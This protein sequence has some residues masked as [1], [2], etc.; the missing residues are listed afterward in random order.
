MMIFTVMAKTRIISPIL[1]IAALAAF[2]LPGAAH[3]QTAQTASAPASAPAPLPGRPL[4]EVIAVAND[5]PILASALNQRIAEVTQALRARGTA[6]PTEEVLRRQVLERL[7]THKLQL[8]AADRQGIRISADQINEALSSIAARNGLTLAELPKALE[9]QGR[10]YLAFRQEIKEQLII[11]QLVRQTVAS[12]IQVTPTE[13]DHY[14]Q[15]QDNASGG[16]VEYRLAQ[17]LVTF[18]A[19]ATPDQ[20][21]KAREKAQALVAQIKAGADFA[22]TAV[23]NSGG[24]HA[25]EGG[26]IG[27]IKA[28]SLPT[29]FAGVVPTLKPGEI[30]APIVGVGG[31]HIVKLVDKRSGLPANTATEYHIR[32]ILLKPNPIRDLEQSKVLAETL[33]KQVLSGEISFAEAAKQYSNDPNSAGIGGD[34]EW[35]TLQRLPPAFEPV[36]KNLAVDQISQPF[37]IPSGWDI[38]KLVGKRRS[39]V[40]QA[41]REHRAYQAIFQRKMTEQLAEFKRSLRSQAYIQVFASAHAGDQNGAD[42]T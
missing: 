19:N 34:L 11:Q 20:V 12:K 26:M 17:I 33:R 29:L 1:G 3:A 13:I 18:P 21:A 25:L 24:P 35:G 16:N 38:V 8:Q 31:F 5:Q 39:N 42:G 14:L 2:A 22:A 6:L 10:N 36:V 27:W 40:T 37:K 15:R 30:S 4:D 23:A 32:H 9:A 7:I 41:Q 28:A